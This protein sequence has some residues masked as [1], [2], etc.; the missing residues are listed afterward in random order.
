MPAI[1]AQI[2]SALNQAASGA[3]APLAVAAASWL[4]YLL[5]AGVLLPLVFEKMRAAGFRLSARI[6][7]GT[8]LGL[9]LRAILG[10]IAF[11]PRP[12]VVFSDINKLIEKSADSPAFP[13]GHAVAGFAIAYGLFLWNRR[14]GTVALI[15]AAIIGI[16]RV[17]VGVHYPSDIIAGALLG[18]LASWLVWRITKRV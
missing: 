11:R 6:V 8:G 4:I 16:G 18:I 10:S 3:F 17:A 13:S 12:F 1:D 5:A 9:V 14:V 2:V 15:L 7:A